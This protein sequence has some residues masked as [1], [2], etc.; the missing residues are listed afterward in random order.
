MTVNAAF[1]ETIGAL[2]AAT[3]G[4]MLARGQLTGPYLFSVQLDETA[5]NGDELTAES[6]A[7]GVWR[8]KVPQGNATGCYWWAAQ[9]NAGGDDPEITD[10][11]AVWLDPGESEVVFLP[12]GWKIIVKATLP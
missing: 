6:T 12:F 5:T 2:P 4:P 10:A 1:A 7:A 11:S 3:A 8:I 9:T